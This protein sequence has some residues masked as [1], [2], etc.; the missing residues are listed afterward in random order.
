M[1]NLEEK[2]YMFKANNIHSTYFYHTKNNQIEYL[3]VIM[4]IDSQKVDALY[5]KITIEELEQ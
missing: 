4:R 3:E 1:K 2:D 5:E